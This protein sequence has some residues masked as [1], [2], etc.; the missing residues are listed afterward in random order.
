MWFCMKAPKD[1]VMPLLTEGIS[2]DLEQPDSFGVRIWIGEG[3]ISKMKLHH[4]MF[5]SLVSEF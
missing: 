5:S 4:E 1:D 2:H 3:E